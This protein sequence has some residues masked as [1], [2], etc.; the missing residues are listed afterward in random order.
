MSAP[1]A[2]GSG[3]SGGLDVEHVRRDFPALGQTIHGK[4]LV[5][6]DSAVSAQKPRV[7][8]DA[9]TA[10]Y[11]FDYSNVHRG[12]HTLSQRA[13]DAY[14][15]AREKG[16]RLLGAALRD[17]VVFVRGTTEGINLVAQSFARPR[18]REGDEVLISAME[19]HSN[20][21]PW[22][23]VCEQ[24]GAKLRVA[25]IRPGGRR[26]AGGPSLRA[27]GDGAFRGAGHRARFVRLL[28]HPPRGRPA[29]RRR[30]HGTGDIRLM[31]LREI[32]QEVILDHY[33]KPRNFSV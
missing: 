20:V 8:L 32:Y 19:H 15:G 10:A 2:A 26:G 6:I 17:E 29:G 4:P 14:E 16:R 30:R 33:R 24:T 1:A 9:V 25:P 13:T 28:Q 7:M 21:V 5:Y 18:L 3:Q 23:L 12:V 31:D 27:T 22:Q 11:T